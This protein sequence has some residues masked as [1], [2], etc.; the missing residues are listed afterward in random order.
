L[1]PGQ[2]LYDFGSLPP[3]IALVVKGQLRLLGRDENGE[4][5][6][7]QRIG[8]GGMAGQVALLRG[9]PGHALAASLPT[10]LWLLPA[11]NFLQALGEQP[12]LNASFSGPS[13]EELY[14]AAAASRRPELPSRVTL[15][16][17][18]ANQMQEAPGEQ[19]VLL[20]PP[21]THS[22]PEGW[23]SWLV[24]SDNL[25]GLE[26]GREV[27]GP[28]ELAVRGKLPGRLLAQPSSWPPL[29]LPAAT[30]RCPI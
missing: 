14:A 30:H 22:F 11:E 10:Q 16:D 27:Q 13:I 17:W 19:Q 23:T 2:K 8:A 5:F 12:S 29:R 9:V 6:T 3:G 20:L 1:R 28:V 21:G 15:R 26:P 4:P 24:S 7:I 25:E 18:A